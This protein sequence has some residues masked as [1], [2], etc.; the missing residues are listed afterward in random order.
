MQISVAGLKLIEQFEGF[1]SARYLDPVGVPTIG[2]GTTASVISPLPAT[3]TQAQAEGWLKLYVERDVQP[4]LNAAVGS[5]AVNQNQYDALCS[6]GYNLGAGI[7]AASHSIGAALHAGNL[8]QVGADFLLYD[9]ANGQVLAGLQARRKAEQK[10]FNTPP[11]PPPPPPDPNHYG[12]F[13]T[14]VRDLGNGHQGSEKAIVTE[15]DVKRKSPNQF[16][17]RLDVLKTDLQALAGRLEA[18]S[19]AG[20][21]MD[22]DR[23][24][25]RLTQL[26]ER[27][28]GQQIV[29]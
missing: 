28:Q 29:H 1:R 19:R 25:W 12:W 17:Q 18:M 26:A 14:Q 9:T 13:D 15:Y 23:R 24:A 10:L 8:G 4:A 3:C 2:F 11:V 20:Q 21:N 5:H 16:P 22:I 27:A 7:F 6:L